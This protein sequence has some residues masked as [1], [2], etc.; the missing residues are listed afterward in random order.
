MIKIL[1]ILPFIF[2]LYCKDHIADPSKMI[3]YFVRIKQRSSVYDQTFLLYRYEMTIVFRGEI[4]EVID[5]KRGWY[6]IKLPEMDL[7]EDPTAIGPMDGWVK[8]RNVSE[9]IIGKDK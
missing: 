6:K 5:K 8:A 7:C 1:F 3:T 4:F 9:V 2:S